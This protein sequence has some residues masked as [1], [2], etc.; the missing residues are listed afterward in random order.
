M[1]YQ[2]GSQRFFNYKK[3]EQKFCHGDAQSLRIDH[4]RIQYPNVPQEH[5]TFF[6]ER[7]STFLVNEFS[8]KNINYVLNLYRLVGKAARGELSIAEKK[9]YSQRGGFILLEGYRNLDETFI[10]KQLDNA[11]YENLPSAEQARSYIPMVKE[12]FEEYLTQILACIRNACA[13]IVLAKV[14]SKKL[15]PEQAATILRP[16]PDQPDQQEQSNIENLINAYN[17]HTI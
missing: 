8:N 11:Y 10:I 6:I 3:L 16:F 15:T 2:V 9:D 5:I 7:I 12:L 17:T 14:V 1:I 13:P 4:Y